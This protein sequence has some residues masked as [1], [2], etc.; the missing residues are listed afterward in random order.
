[1]VISIEKNNLKILL[2]NAP[3]FRLFSKGASY[4]QLGILS[5]AAVLKNNNFEVSVYDSDFN[6]RFVRKPAYGLG[7]P[8]NFFENYEKNLYNKKFFVWREIER[9]IDKINPNIVGITFTTFDYISALTVAKIVKKINNKIIT[10]VGGHHVNALPTETMKEKFF[11]IGVLGEGEFTM[12]ELV[13]TLSKNKKINKIKG[14]I[15]RK[16][17][18]IFKTKPRL[19]INNLDKLPF[20]ARELLINKGRYLPHIMGNMITSR[21]CPYN[22]DFCTTSP[23]YGN[24]IRL[25]SAENVFEEMKK[26]NSEYNT[27]F[28]TF[29]DDLFTFSKKRVNDLCDLIK[30]NKLDFMWTCITRADLLDRDIVEKMKSAGCY[31]ISIG[32]ETGSQELLNKMQKNIDIERLRRASKMIKDMGINL[33]LFFSVGHADETENSLK[34]TERMVKE[35]DPDTLNVSLVN[36]FPGTRIYKNAIKEK[37]FAFKNWHDYSMKL[38]NVDEDTFKKYFI[39]MRAHVY[40][41]NLI[42]IKKM[43]TRPDFIIKFSKENIKSTKDLIIYATEFIKTQFESLSIN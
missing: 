21:G 38:K 43:I 18:R 29:H 23:M 11:D 30:K 40:R 36:P 4:L 27:L 2:V 24:T 12:L 25:R 39:R 20:P 19:F 16:S 34:D 10:V 32:A 1:M 42:G 35:L 9:T 22:C 7:Y 33:H 15:F 14:I 3:H 8:P 6:A 37:R 26:V 17:N 31:G 41:K 13:E 5:I 28:F